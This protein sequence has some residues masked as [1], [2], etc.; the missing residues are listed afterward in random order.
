[1]PLAIGQGTRLVRF[2]TAADKDYEATIRF[3][4]TTDT[5]DVTGVETSRS[6]ARP[7]REAVVAALDALRGE[8]LQTP[9]AYS[10]KKVQGRRA[11]SLA[12]SNNDVAL[13]PVSVRVSRA[14]LLEYTDAYARVA[15]TCSAG[16]YVRSFAHALG[17]STGTGAC[18]EALRRTRSGD[19]RL[20]DAVPIEALGDAHRVRGCLIPLEKLLPRFPA[21]TVTASG[22]AHVAHGRELAAEEYLP[23]FAVDPAPDAVSWVRLLDAGGR[24]VAVATRG[25]RPGSLHP[26]VVLI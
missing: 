17:T 12:R 4:V 26:S 3:G 23:P 18:L 13:N 7:A 15:L 2:L 25:A 6:D 5:Y 21:V 11:Y 22:R 19:F 10:A 24:L 16:F 1:L 14:D 8:Y 9:P 20:E